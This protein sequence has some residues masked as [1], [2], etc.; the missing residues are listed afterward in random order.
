M[1]WRVSVEAVQV[2]CSNDG[3]HGMDAGINGSSSRCVRGEH[4]RQ[5]GGTWKELGTE[6]EG[7][8]GGRKPIHDS[9]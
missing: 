5:A 7:V 8:N 2:Y 3:E 4:S 9:I 1:Q 6:R